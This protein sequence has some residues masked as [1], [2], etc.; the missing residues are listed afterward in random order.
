MDNFPKAWLVNPSDINM[1]R[2]IKIVFFIFVKIGD[3]V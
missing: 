1:Q 3:N 2:Q